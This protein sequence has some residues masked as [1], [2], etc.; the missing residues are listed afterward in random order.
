M[1]CLA[2]PLPLSEDL[3]RSL[4]ATVFLYQRVVIHTPFCCVSLLEEWREYLRTAD[5]VS[6]GVAQL[7]FAVQTE[8][9]NSISGA[10]RL[11]SQL[12]AEFPLGSTLGAQAHPLAVAW[13]AEWGDSS[14]HRCLGLGR[15]LLSK[16][17]AAATAFA[18]NV[19]Y[20]FYLNELKHCCSCL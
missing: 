13:A 16:L 8:V 6:V 12:A 7:G 18:G 15:F 11:L 3:P 19:V 2:L 10:S 20:S 5:V 17:V 9:V 1:L 14:T 4:S